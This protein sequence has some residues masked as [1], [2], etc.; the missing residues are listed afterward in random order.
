MIK[1]NK[2]IIVICI[3]NLLGCGYQPIFYNSDFN[4]S[5]ENIEQTGSR[6]VNSILIDK[7]R[8]I[9]KGKSL[10]YDLKLSSILPAIIRLANCGAIRGAGFVDRI[11]LRAF[12]ATTFLL[13]APLGTT[14]SRDTDT[15]A[16]AT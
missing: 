12:S 5:I 15:P 3:F 6:K 14:S 2:I 11:F 10:T 7:I 1:I 16:L 4:F 13:L 9:K 8:N